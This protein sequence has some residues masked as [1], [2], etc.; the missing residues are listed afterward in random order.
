MKFSTFIVVDDPLRGYSRPQE[1]TMNGEVYFP[2]ET[3]MPIILKGKGCIGIGMIHKMTITKSSTTIKFE[4]TKINDND[5]NAYYALY[6]N[7]VSV[8]DNTDS[9]DQTDVIIPGMVS[10]VKPRK[11][12]IED[13]YDYRRR[14]NRGILDIANDDDDFDWD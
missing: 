6:R 13:D 11:A 14:R 10:S 3:P 2:L 9:Y 7:Q 8:S 1:R 12:N 5:A 4:A